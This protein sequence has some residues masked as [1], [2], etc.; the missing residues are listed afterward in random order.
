[1]QSERDSALHL[2][3]GLGEVDAEVVVGIEAPGDGDH[4]PGQP[5]STRQPREDT[6]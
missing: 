5:E 3:D 4:L 6:Q 1:M 2:F